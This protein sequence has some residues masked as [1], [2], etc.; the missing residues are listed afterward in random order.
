LNELLDTEQPSGATCSP[1]EILAVR[2]MTPDREE[3]VR[4]AV[5]HLVAAIL[6]VVREETTPAQAPSD[7]LLS[8]GQAASAL[9]IGR[10]ALYQE[11][12]AGRL[13]S[14]RVGRRRLVPMSAIDAYIEAGAIPLGHDQGDVNSQGFATATAAPRLVGLLTRDLGTPG[15]FEE[16]RR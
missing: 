8:I 16:R 6:A 3:A 5:D 15:K 12:G 10:T 2:A 14:F 7:R 11:L 1:I 4:A 13:R 9:G